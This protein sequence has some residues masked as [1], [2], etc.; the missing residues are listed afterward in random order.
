MMD[1]PENRRFSHS[2]DGWTSR[3]WGR[4]GNGSASSAGPFKWLI[5]ENNRQNNCSVSS[6]AKHAMQYG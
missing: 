2:F 1:E 5:P 3:P 4:G 6:I